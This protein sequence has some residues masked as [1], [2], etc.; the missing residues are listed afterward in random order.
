MTYIATDEHIDYWVV[1]SAPSLPRRPGVQG[2]QYIRLQKGKLGREAGRRS[3]NF[4]LVYLTTRFA[5][6]TLDHGTGTHH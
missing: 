3:I 6:E 4:Q 5:V 2:A 1:R